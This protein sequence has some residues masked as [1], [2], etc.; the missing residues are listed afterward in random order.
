[1]PAKEPANRPSTDLPAAP[2]DSTRDRGG[3]KNGAPV[4]GGALP[5]SVPN[6]VLSLDPPRIAVYSEPH[7]P[8]LVIPVFVRPPHH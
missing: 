1:M 8:P 4:E 5:G 3:I 2:T 7:S 6:P